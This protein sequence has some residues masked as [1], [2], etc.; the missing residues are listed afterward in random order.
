MALTLSFACTFLSC[1]SWEGPV[2]AGRSPP[3]RRGH[4]TPRYGYASVDF[5]W[6]CA[7]GFSPCCYA[8]SKA[9]FFFF[10]RSWLHG[11]FP[12]HSFSVVTS[13][14]FHRVD[15]FACWPPSLIG[16]PVPGFFYPPPRRWGRS[17]FPFTPVTSIARGLFSPRRSIF[18]DFVP[19]PATIHSLTL[20]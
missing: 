4:P 8:P 17:C 3:G 7:F 1:L 20:P 6:D 10:N 2:T 13:V 14:L 11:N 5:F 15:C 19:C 16:L 9:Q 18:A 12:L